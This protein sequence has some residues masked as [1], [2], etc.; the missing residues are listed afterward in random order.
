VALARITIRLARAGADP[1]AKGRELLDPLIG[2][3]PAAGQRGGG[4]NRVVDFADPRDAR[5]LFEHARALLGTAADGRV[6]FHTCLHA[7][8][9]AAGVSCRLAPDFEEVAG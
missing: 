1:D 4:R 3:L 2:T 6:S 5:V 9:P 7:D 8:A